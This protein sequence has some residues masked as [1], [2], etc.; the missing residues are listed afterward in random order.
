MKK[1]IAILMLAG[2]LVYFAAERVGRADCNPQC[3]YADD[4][5]VCCT[6]A[7]CFDFCS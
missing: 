5:R 2:A 7:N 3:W 6:D 4:G 1:R